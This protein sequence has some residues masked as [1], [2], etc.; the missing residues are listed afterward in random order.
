HPIA[1]VATDRRR[2]CN[3]GRPAGASTDARELD[4][5]APPVRASVKTH[6]GPVPV[7]RRKRHGVFQVPP[8]VGRL[9]TRAREARP[10][11]T[12]AADPLPG[13]RPPTPPAGAVPRWPAR[14]RDSH[15]PAHARPPTPPAGA[16]PRWPARSR[17]SHALAHA[18]PHTSRLCS[19]TA[20]RARAVSPYPATYRNASHGIGWMLPNASSML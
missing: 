14:S 10:H 12:G 19:A 7:R 17:D 15:A 18:R 13:A 8:W 2:V 16:V 4:G 11:G 1:R 9:T 5:Y 20:A 3:S 6:S